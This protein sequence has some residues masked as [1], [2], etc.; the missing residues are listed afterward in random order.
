MEICPPLGKREKLKNASKSERAAA[1]PISGMLRPL[2][3][4]A[5]L[6]KQKAISP[7]L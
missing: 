1:T 4:D 3:P 5:G 6:A 2:P 7:N